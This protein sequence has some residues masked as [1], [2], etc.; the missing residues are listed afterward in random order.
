MPTPPII[1]FG[2]F[3]K[4]STMLTITRWFVLLNANP[5]YTQ[6]Y[7]SVFHVDAREIPGKFYYIFQLLA[8]T[9]HPETDIAA[10]V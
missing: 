10:D 6:D 8:Y 1:G 3:T 2:A 7:F 9:W 5:A 4:G